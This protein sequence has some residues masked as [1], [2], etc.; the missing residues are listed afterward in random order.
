M[1]RT[2]NT[3]NFADF[4][5]NSEIN[6]R[7]AYDQYPKRAAQIYDIENTDMYT[8][9]ESSLDGFTVAKVKRE[10]SDFAYLDVTQDY[11]KTWTIYEVGGMTKIT[12]LMR[13]ANKYREMNNRIAGLGES[14]AKRM[15]WDLTHRLT[16]AD[17][18]SYTNIDGDTVSTTCG[19]GFQLA[20][21][22]HTVSGS[23]TTYR[24]RVANNPVLSKG[25]LEAAEKLFAT[26][27]ID[28]NGELILSEPD[29]LITSNDPNTVNTALEYLR[30][31]SAPDAGVAGVDNVY[32]GKY[33]LLVLPW[34][35][36]TPSTGAYNSSDAKFW[37]LA[38]L[39]NT[40]AVCKIM[41]NPTFI[42][43]TMNDGKEFETMDWKFACHAAYAIEIVRA[44]WIVFSS[45]DGTA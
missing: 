29:T 33:R 17:A 23:S 8:G 10:G 11:T 38:D 42:P 39:K 43:P 20:Y 4:V 16:E 13:R 41:Q 37:F 34:L 18:T 25:G 12:W 22:A 3:T 31:V 14:A 27:M 9:T 26:Q 40:D 1:A 24:N 45:G 28:A 35:A 32:K 6:F 2:I 21:T 44:T 7:R 19:D 15:E 30:S 5:A 36:T